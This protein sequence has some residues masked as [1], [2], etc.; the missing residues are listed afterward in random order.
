LT[1]DKS[2]QLEALASEVDA[3]SDSPLYS[4]R[5]ENS[6]R[7]VFGEGDSEARV[8]FIGEAPGK[9]EAMRGQPFVGA[10][11]RV[12]DDLLRS[13]GLERKD[14]YITNILKDRPP[15]NRDPR[16]E[17]IALYVPFLRRQLEIIQPRIIVTLGR[18]AM[19]F[20]FEEFNMPEQ[21]GS[22]SVLHG[23]PLQARAS[24][25]AITV[26]P[27]FHPAVTFYRREQREI[28]KRDFQSLRSELDR[29]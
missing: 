15:E 9:Q 24:Y 11:G 23:K 28:L 12:L 27:L 25:G 16:K 6:Y 22:I 29:I 20:I 1:K 7:I 2:K 19:E 14:V 3:L 5:K 4:Y 10:A 8:M 26:L 21:G 18:F 17:E 13:V